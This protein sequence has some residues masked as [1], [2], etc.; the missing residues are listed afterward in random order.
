MNTDINALRAENRKL[1]EKNTALSVQIEAPEKALAAAA[2]KITGLQ[3]EID[4]L[5]EE[6]AA[7]ETAQAEALAAM[8]VRIDEQTQRAADAVT[9]SELLHRAL[10]ADEAGDMNGLQ[11]LLDRIEELKDL[12]SPTEADIYE[13]LKIA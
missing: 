9:V 13:E 12:L 5:Q 6:A 4:R 3:A 1:S 10:A 2:T 8:Q 7:R 11:K